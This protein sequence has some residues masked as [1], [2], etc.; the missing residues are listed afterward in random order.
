MQQ[1][2]L[3]RARHWVESVQQGDGG[4]G[5]RCN[6]YDDPV[7]KGQGP[8][9]ATQTAWAVMG[10][11]AFDDPDRA[12]PVEAKAI[13]SK[14]QVNTSLASFFGVMFSPHANDFDGNGTANDGQQRAQCA[15]SQGQQ[16]ALGQELPNDA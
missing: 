8:T 3:L 14:M 7:F 5:E 13:T 4:W 9:T 1:P 15:A 2:W 6:T 11:C 12:A 16:S 10:L